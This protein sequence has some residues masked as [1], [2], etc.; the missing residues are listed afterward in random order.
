M[1]I[2]THECGSEVKIIIHG[3]FVFSCH[4]DFN[5]VMH[6]YNGEDTHYTVDLSGTTYLDSSALGMLLLL[7]DHAGNDFSR[8][9][10][11]SPPS[12]VRQ[13][14]EYANFGHKFTID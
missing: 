8:V 14:L 9:Q 7:R 13:L 4:R 11:R 6:R 1:T 12:H 10:L 3:R 5:A 2:T